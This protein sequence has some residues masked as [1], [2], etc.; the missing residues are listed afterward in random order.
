MFS[1]VGENVRMRSIPKLITATAALALVL[2]GCV[3][4]EPEPTPTVSTPGPSVAPGPSPTEQPAEVAAVEPTG[5]I[6][7]LATGLTSPWS[8]AILDGGSALIS[9]RDTARIIELTPGGETRIV[10]TIS[11]V[12]HGG[13]GGLLGIEVV[14]TGDSLWLFAYHTASG[15]NRVVRMPLLGEPGSLSLGASEILLTGI[16]RA[17]NHNGGR[18]KQ[19]PDGHLY[20]T[21]GDAANPS[22]SQDP[23]SLAGKILR[24]TFAGTAPDDN[25]TPGSLVYSIGHRNPQGIAWDSAGQLWAAEFGQNTWDELNVIMPG[26][27]YGWPVVEGTGGDDRFRDPIIVWSTAEASPSGLAIAGDT[28]FL[29][30]LRGQ[31]LWAVYATV[32]PNGTVMQGPDAEAWFTGELG[33]IRDVVAAPDGTLWILTNN[34]DGRGSPRAGDDRLIEVE[35]RERT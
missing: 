20:V 28:L 15:D 6:R 29:A 34:T 27:N 12:R 10:G 18:I 19:G 17:G 21:T 26:A 14:D 7:D 31:R 35:L 2:A 5:S 24:M 1:G 16:P 4:A 9:E 22:L 33:R 25:P 32:D 13:E 30:A 11:G 3:S 23:G 8:V